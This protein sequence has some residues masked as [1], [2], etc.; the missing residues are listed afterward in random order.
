MTSPFQDV[1]PHCGTCEMPFDNVDLLRRHGMHCHG[2]R[3]GGREGKRTKRYKEKLKRLCAF[4]KGAKRRRVD[5]IIAREGRSRV[6]EG[7]PPVD[8]SEPEVGT[9]APLIFTDR[10][11]TVLYIDAP[12]PTMRL[13][14]QLHDLHD[15]DPAV[16]DLLVHAHSL[17]ASMTQADA[18][19]FRAL[20]T[21]PLLQRMMPALQEAWAQ[22]PGSRE[23]LRR[24]VGDSERHVVPGVGEVVVHEFG[25][26]I[27][28]MLR[29][30]ARAFGRDLR[31]EDFFPGDDEG[32]LTF[33]SAARWRR[34]CAALE[35]EDRGDR[36]RPALLP[37]AIA[38]SIDGTEIKGSKG[39]TPFYGAIVG[40]GVSV[41][42]VRAT[43]PPVPHRRAGH[44][45]PRWR[46][47]GDS[48][49]L[50]DVL[51]RP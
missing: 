3:V 15:Q 41:F 29:L 1:F 24:V 43:L 50:S 8:Q 12:A 46:C 6:E 45:P 31:D 42:H 25:R 36:R 17:E 40:L 16:G 27:G 51:C 5:E 30:A 21:S 2:P 48:Q 23:I 47:P 11:E 44:C 19:Q 34:V 26:T 32:T 28:D 7:H 9:G 35:R 18:R 38:C 13:I 39:V 49:E 22:S 33:R 4:T 10:E 37:V 20:M 14:Q